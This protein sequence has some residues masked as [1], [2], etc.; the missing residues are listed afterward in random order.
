MKAALESDDMTVPRQANDNRATARSWGRA[1]PDPAV[2]L[3]LLELVRTVGEITDDETEIV[4]TVI[5]MLR[6][7]TVKLAGSFRNEP[8]RHLVD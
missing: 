8:I 3:T 1:R 2:H 5:H 4:A 7:G 6:S